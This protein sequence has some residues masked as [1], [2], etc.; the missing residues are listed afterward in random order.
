MELHDLGGY[1]IGN[2]YFL[3]PFFLLLHYDRSSIHPSVVLLT[4]SAKSR[5]IY[6]W[7]QGG[8]RVG[9]GGGGKEKRRLLYFVWD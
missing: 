1:R 7:W 5:I 6:V 4:L 2:D 8:R 9:G 3:R